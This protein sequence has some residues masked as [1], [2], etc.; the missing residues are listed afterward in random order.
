ME[1]TEEKNYHKPNTTV[2]WN[3]RHGSYTLKPLE[4]ESVQMTYE[5]AIK[6]MK[7]RVALQE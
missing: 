2:Y 7:E 5:D 3:P 4:E 6:T 1:S